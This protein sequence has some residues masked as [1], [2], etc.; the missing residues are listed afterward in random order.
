MSW[1]W[2]DYIHRELSLTREER[3]GILRLLDPEGNPV[4]IDQHR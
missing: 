1:V 4:L 3:K 2:P